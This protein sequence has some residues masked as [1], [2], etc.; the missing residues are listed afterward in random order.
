MKKNI[1]LAIIS[2]L[3]MAN[4]AFGQL[5][6]SHNDYEHARPFYDAYDLGFDSIEADLYLK[7]GDLYVAHDW[8]N[9]AED[10]TFKAL[11]LEPLLARIKAN[12]GYAYPD[13]KKLYLLLDLKKDGRLIMAELEK[14]LKP[15]RKELKHV[16]ITISGDMP[17]PEEFEQ[18]DKLF[19]FDG[20]K[21]TVYSDKAYKR[22]DMVSASFTDFG[23]YWPGKQEMPE[24]TYQK[25]SEFVMF[26]HARGKRVRLWGTANTLLTFETLKKLGVD[27]IGTDDLQLL[28]NFVL[29]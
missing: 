27:F 5:M 14:L 2:M 9:I 13:K 15:H 17:K 1:R 26:N 8:K 24:E 16:Q 20:R 19:Y 4:Q 3:L 7:D 11:Y 6:H 22:V 25:I 10:R 18:Y 21:T 23:K 12:K 28:N 29:K